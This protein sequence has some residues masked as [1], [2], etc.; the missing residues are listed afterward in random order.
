MKV[1]IGWLGDS[2]HRGCSGWLRRN[3]LRRGNILVGF[4][5]LIHLQ[6]T[7]IESELHHLPMARL[8]FRSSGLIR[9]SRCLNYYLVFTGWQ[10]PLN[11]HPAEVDAANQHLGV[12]AVRSD[13]EQTVGVLEFDDRVSVRIRSKPLSKGS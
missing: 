13:R 12:R 7:F 2:D 10:N 3:S 6:S 8:N 4:I 1:V 5:G 9:R 11:R